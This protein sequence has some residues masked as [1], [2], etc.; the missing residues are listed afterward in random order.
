MKSNDIDRPVVRKT[1]ARAFYLK[2]SAEWLTG[3]K[4]VPSAVLADAEQ[5]ARGVLVR[6]ACQP[7]AHIKLPAPERGAASLSTNTPT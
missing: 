4:R 3:K 1:A 7:K 2:M 6:H 5:A